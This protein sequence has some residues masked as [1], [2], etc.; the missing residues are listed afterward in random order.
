MSVGNAY[1]VTSTI[2]YL[3]ITVVTKS[4]E[5]VVGILVGNLRGIVVGA[6]A[7]WACLGHHTGHCGHLEHSELEKEIIKA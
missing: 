7:G 5:E 2:G 1:G 6:V 4:L 3:V